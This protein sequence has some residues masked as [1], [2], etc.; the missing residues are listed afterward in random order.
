MKLSSRVLTIATVLFLS[1]GCDQAV[2]I[3]AKRSLENVAPLS[4]FHDFVR[5]QYA[6]NSGIMLSIGAGLSPGA[7]FWAFIVVVGILLGAILLYT[8][9]SREMDRTQ[10]V[11]WTLIASGGLANLL[12]RVTKN[13]VVIDYISI[14][15]GVVRTAVFNIAD[16]LV[17]V[18]VF[19]L[20]LHGTRKSTPDAPTK[21]SQDGSP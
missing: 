6:E 16:T 1:I 13:G 11:A 4:L 21:I 20:L 17:F 10:A 2:K 14:G 9:W 18:G 8:V 19:L 3:L 5:L 15:I 7:R 12:D